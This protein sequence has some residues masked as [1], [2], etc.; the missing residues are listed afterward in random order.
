MITLAVVG[1]SSLADEGKF[2]IR[3]LISDNYDRPFNLYRSRSQLFIT[4][5]IILNSLHEHRRF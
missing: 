4:A 2:I 5:L 3:V 1:G